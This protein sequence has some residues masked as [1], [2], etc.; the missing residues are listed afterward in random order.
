MEQ[1]EVL[2]YRGRLTTVANKFHKN[3]TINCCKSEPLITIG[4]SIIRRDFI[5]SR[6]RLWTLPAI[7]DLA[8]YKKGMRD[9]GQK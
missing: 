7:F 2:R 1:G 6:A 5:A 4:S 9:D 8:I 3:C